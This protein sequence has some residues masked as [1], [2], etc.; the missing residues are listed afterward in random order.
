MLWAM[1]GQAL[2][3]DQSCTK[4][5][6]RIQAHRARLGLA[7]LSDDTGGYC[8]ARQ[9]MPEGLFSS[10]CRRVGAALTVRAQA[11]Q[12]WCGRRVK[13]VDG[14]SSSMPDTRQNQAAYTQPSSQKPG[15]GFPLMAYVAVFCLA[16]GAALDLALGP[17]FQRD[18]ALFY[19]L[20]DSFAWGDVLL[21]DRA[22]CA[23]AEIAF[24]QQRGVDTVL[25]LHQS[26]RAD[27]RRGKVIG[28]LDHIVTWTK[29]KRR[30]RGLRP[31]DYEQ[32][33]NSLTLREVRYQVETKGFRTHTL[34][35][36]TTLLD[37]GQYPVADLADLYFRR[38]E[39][40]LDFRH[41]KTTLQMDVLRGKS[42]DVV[43]KEVWTHLLAYN[44]IRSVM[45]DAAQTHGALPRRLSVKGTVQQV[46]AHNDLLATAAPQE[47]MRLLAALSERVAGQL[48]PLRPGRVEPRVRKR[49]PKSYPFMTKPRAQ[50]KE[51]LCA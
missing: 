32:L 8:R 22:F 5:L 16:T 14:S 42:P 18:L 10:L 1:V 31:E 29:P 34:T 51:K 41:L 4:T 40:E 47:H 37:A 17:W 27:F 28:L 30:P 39:I 15:C 13:V 38:W 33:P 26:R 20:R 46:Q 44:L 35:L 48:V 25:R 2:D 36:V 49:R 45:W 23:Y 11:S 3:P 24:L 6:A 50:L 9:R 12:L 7:P 43:R 19:L 21:A